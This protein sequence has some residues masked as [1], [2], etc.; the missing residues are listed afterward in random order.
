MNF[1]ILHAGPLNLYYSQ[2]DLRYISLGKREIVRRIYFAARDRTWGTAPNV[3]HDVQ[4]DDGGDCFQI[5]YTCENIFNDI[6]FIWQG[7]IVGSAEGCITVSM[8]GIAR[9][10][11][12]K[13]HI[14]LCV[15]HPAACSGVACEVLHVDGTRSA[16][17]LPKRIHPYQP[18]AP[19]DN[20]RGFRQHIH[21]EAW[22]DLQYEGELFE[23]EDQRNWTDASFKTFSTPLRLPYPV[24][25]QKGDRVAQKITLRVTGLTHAKAKS[26]VRAALP[27]RILIGQREISLP[28][29][30]LSMAPDTQRLQGIA[31]DQLR[32][33]KLGHLRVALYLANDDYVAN[34][35]RAGR[36]SVDLGVPL[37]V[38]LFMPTTEPE[39]VFQA[40]A[41]Q[42]QLLQAQG[43]ILNIKRWLIYCARDAQPEIMPLRTL[44]LLARQWL[45][46]CAPGARFAFGVD[47]DFI[48][49]NQHPAALRGLDALTIAINPQVHAFDDASLV[50]T[51][52]A[53]ETL[54]NHARRLAHGV[55]IIISPITL[56]PR[57]NPISESNDARQHT[58]FGAAWTLGS[59]KY[60][61]RAGTSSLTYF[62]TLG[63]RGVGDMQ[64][65]FPVY[66]I[67]S[68]LSEFAGGVMIDSVSRVPLH[69]DCIVLRKGERMS[70]FI[71]NF[72]DR[73]VV[74]ALNK[75]MPNS[76]CVLVG[77]DFPLKMQI[78][79][80]HL[81][82]FEVTKQSITRLD[83]SDLLS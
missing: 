77:D 53:Q 16:G 78:S 23:M 5:R 19:F 50:E 1:Q 62:E 71:I 68:A 56:K 72:T 52:V 49:I 46:R 30:G 18:I 39:V 75:A 82:T 80:N 13:N 47:S 10:R 54:V 24:E 73:A 57:R 40:L 28:T 61:A 32:A 59:I 79:R 21:K 2:G 45:T 43:E 70:A 26:K 41:K 51:L 14:G 9:S 37:E 44:Q 63:E 11:F 3:L 8:N 33:L 7:E 83:W 76:H 20:I 4:L 34:L 69:I 81:L 64:G 67:L 55:P 66:W 22:L 31:L 60:L 65:M 38:A 12:Q 35:Q 29:I 15:L 74:V 17:N 58:W 42:V 27:A 6:D 48:F 25:M 36:E